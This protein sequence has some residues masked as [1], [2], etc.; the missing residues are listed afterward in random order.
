MN[1]KKFSLVAHLDLTVSD[2]CLRR[3]CALGQNGLTVS[4]LD[5]VHPEGKGKGMDP[6]KLSIY[7]VWQMNK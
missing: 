3:G 6:S 5:V 4:A 2:L 7:C 1:S